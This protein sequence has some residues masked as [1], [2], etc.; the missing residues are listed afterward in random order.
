MRSRA[1]LSGVLHAKG[2]GP[3]EP[4]AILW[5][6]G[7]LLAPYVVLLFE[8]DLAGLGFLHQLQA[9]THLALEC[10][11]LRFELTNLR[12]Q[13]GVS[14]VAELCVRVV[15]NVVLVLKVQVGSIDLIVL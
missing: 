10:L 7:R 1:Q 13:S 3:H 11:L 14:T 15:E 9:G 12:D 4:H 6:D 2:R 5:V 8:Q